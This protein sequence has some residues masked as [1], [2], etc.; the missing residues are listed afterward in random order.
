MQ[1]FNYRAFVAH[2]IVKANKVLVIYT[3]KESSQLS[4]QIIYCNPW[5][6]FS[7][8]IFMNGF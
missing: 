8:N 1:F 6:C 4:L 7:S 2:A 5:F 3:L